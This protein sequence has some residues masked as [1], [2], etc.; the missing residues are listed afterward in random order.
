MYRWAMRVFAFFV[1]VLPALVAAGVGWQT[2]FGQAAEPLFFEVM[3]AGVLPVLLVACIVQYA[4]VFGRVMSADVPKEDMELVRYEHSRLTHLYGSIFLAGEGI[5]LY[6]VA[7]DKQTTF[8]LLAASFYALI[9]LIMLLGEVN[10]LSDS[11]ESFLPAGMR[12]E[13]RDR[14][15]KFADRHEELASRARAVAGRSEEE[16]SNP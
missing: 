9:L 7:A 5:A 10:A 4:V 1:L 6:A 16:E 11:P 14:L 8:L 15:R 13:R 3:A 12:R 2:A